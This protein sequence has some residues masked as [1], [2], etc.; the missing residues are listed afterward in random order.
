MKNINTA[1]TID[2]EDWF[3][4]IISVNNS[5]DSQKGLENR[6]IESTLSCL[7][8]L[9]KSKVKATFFILGCL[10]EQAPNLIKEIHKEGHEIAS[11]GWNHQLVYNLSHDDFYE[12]IYKTKNIL[13]DIINESVYGYRAP[14]FSITKKSLWALPILEKVGYIYD[15]SIHPFKNFMYGIQGAP[16]SCYY[17]TPRLL[18]IPP[19]CIEV[20]GLRIPWAGGLYFRILPY[21][22]FKF[23]FDKYC[24][25]NRTIYFHTADFDI[26]QPYLKCSLLEKFIHYYGLKS[27]PNKMEKFIYDYNPSTIDNVYHNFLCKLKK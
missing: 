23:G 6:F 17:P 13:E 7:K 10:A 9:S 8:T 4:G 2:L 27:L 19:T 14:Y 3:H 25:N 18:E 5:L 12:S 22:V 21:K 15:A 26:Y 24:N 20:L 1:I 16:T 11:H